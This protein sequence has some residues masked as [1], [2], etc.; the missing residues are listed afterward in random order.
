MA[1]T[2]FIKNGVTINVI[3]I[4]DISKLPSTAVIGFDENNN[5]ITVAECDLTLVTNVGSVG[6]LYDPTDGFYRQADATAQTV[7]VSTTTNTSS[8]TAT[9]GG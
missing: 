5:P 3:N 8:N 4:D 6:D 1:R 7:T 9:S 2:A